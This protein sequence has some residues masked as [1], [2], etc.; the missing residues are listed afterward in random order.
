MGVS[1]GLTAGQGAGVAS[2]TSGGWP[3]GEEAR[4]LDLA[5]TGDVMLGAT[6]VGL[7]PDAARGALTPVAPLLRAD[8]TVGNIE[9][10]LTDASGSKCAPPAPGAA[11]TCYAFRSPPSYAAVMARAG[12]SVMTQANNHAYDFGPAGY[13]DT[14][15]A[16]RDNGIA[17][18][19][20]PGSVAR[21]R[22]KGVRVAVVA[23][24]PYPW[25]NSL[26]DV[27][28]ARR[29]VAHAAAGSDV[30]VV[31]MHAGAEGADASRTPVGTETYLGENR[32]D[33]RAFAHA[34]VDAGADLVVGHG[35]HVLRGVEVYR[36]RLIAHSLGNF[37]GYRAFSVHGALGTSAVLRVTVRADGGITRA[38]IHPV[39]LTAEG[40]P[41]P[42]GDAVAT[43]RALSQRDFG[44]A[45]PAIA[46]DGT[47]RPRP[48]GVR[49]SDDWTTARAAPTP[50]DDPAAT[51]P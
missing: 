8:V 14:R 5:F 4:S 10:T 38:R 27:A 16:L 31:T 25:A 40:L 12:F 7:P 21:I 37:A 41:R 44:R 36:G 39:A 19:G 48:D 20:A 2:P 42:G 45:A 13:D 50:A 22:V 6:D 29:L 17:A 28:G 26:T 11:V 35:P 24:A 9:G 49:A 23:F 1:L 47:I 18:T 32:G 33:A 3:E 15:R 46:A 30:V 34:V 43:I 51:I